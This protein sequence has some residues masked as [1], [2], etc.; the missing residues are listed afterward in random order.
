MSIIGVL[1]PY[2]L[3]PFIP[4]HTRRVGGSLPGEL[5]KKISPWQ[6]TAD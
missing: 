6:L 5:D 4:H 3:P 1:N 2:D